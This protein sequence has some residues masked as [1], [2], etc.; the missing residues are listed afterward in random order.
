MSTPITLPRT[1]GVHAPAPEVETDH[2]RAVRL[3]GLL[4]RPPLSWW[5][6]AVDADGE[7]VFLGRFRDALSLQCAISGDTRDRDLYGRPGASYDAS[8]YADPTAE[9]WDHTLAWSLCLVIPS[10]DGILPEVE[11]L[12]G[13]WATEAELDAAHDAAEEQFPGHEL[14]WDGPEEAS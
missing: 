10:P 12:L 14:R 6:W 13:T 2:Q 11:V 4:S 1:P 9:P 5:L 8:H 7:S 3:R